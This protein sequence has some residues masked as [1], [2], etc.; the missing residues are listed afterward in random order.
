M[1][2]NYEVNYEDAR[3]GSVE[4]DKNQASQELEQ[5]YAGMI[6]DSDSFYQAQID[7]S[8][9]W[10]EEQSQIQQEQTDFAIEQIE[11]Q[12]DQAHKDYIKEQSGAYVDWRKQSNQYGT[13][14]E[15]MASAGL[16]NTGYS[17]SSQ[18]SMY[19][20]GQYLQQQLLGQE[21]RNL[22]RAVR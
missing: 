8:K 12:K 5:T 16:E 11:Q 3:F 7:E 9:R 14:A 2:N 21:R 1:A 20:N 17:E 10:A 15:K 4:A 18:V 13:E 6:D 22:L 19:N